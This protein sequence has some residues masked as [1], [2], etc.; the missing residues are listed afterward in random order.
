MSGAKQT[1]TCDKLSETGYRSEKRYVNRSNKHKR[2]NSRHPNFV[3]HHSQTAFCGNSFLN[4]APEWGR[5]SVAWRL[6]G[7][8]DIQG[9]RAMTNQTKLTVENKFGDPGAQRRPAF[10]ASPSQ[11]QMIA[12]DSHKPP[13]LDLS[14]FAPISDLT[15][16]SGLWEV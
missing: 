2:A 1:A 4:A 9:R 7:S 5:Q 6:R 10:D 16:H 8:I 12:D 11:T 14:S 15:E 3:A 13:A